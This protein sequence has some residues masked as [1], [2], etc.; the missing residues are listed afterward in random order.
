MVTPPIE[1]IQLTVVGRQYPRRM[2]NEL[3]QSVFYRRNI[4]STIFKTFC[5]NKIKQAAFTPIYHLF[6]RRSYS[7]ARKFKICLIIPC[8]HLRSSYFLGF[9]KYQLNIISFCE[10]FPSISIMVS[11]TK[12]L[13]LLRQH[14]C[15]FPNTTLHFFTKR[16]L[17]RNMSH[18]YSCEN[19]KK[20]YKNYTLHFSG[21]L[22]INHF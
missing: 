22:L 5:P 16:L 15:Y 7:I 19:K 10:M 20:R 18:R 21:I 6:S 13:R 14:F 9:R 12:S 17:Y 1:I 2:R 8:R 3:T 4:F 11:R